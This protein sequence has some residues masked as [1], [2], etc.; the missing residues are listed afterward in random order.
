MKTQLDKECSAPMYSIHSNPI[1]ES[2]AYL[3][4]CGW[5]REQAQN[6]CRAIQ[7]DSAEKLW[8]LAPKWI[9]HCG[10]SMKYVHAMLGVVATG[11]IKV[12]QAD[13]G[14]WMFGLNDASIEMG[15]QLGLNHE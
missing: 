12:T 7:A 11:V 15:K 13:D 2:I 8:E 5:S 10:Q 6:L 3:E 4:E 1:S 14:D 9:E